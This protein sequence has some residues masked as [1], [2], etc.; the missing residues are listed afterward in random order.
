MAMGDQR[1]SVTKLRVYL[2][3]DSAIMSPVLR[4]LIEATG[5]RIVGNSGAARTSIEDIKVLRP[6][7]V[8]VD[9]MLPGMDGFETAQI[10]RGRERSRHTPII[11]LTAINTSDTHVSRG[12]ELGA[13]DYLPKPF[14]PDQVRHAARRVV[15]ANVLRR[16]MS[17]LQD[18]LDESEGE[19]T[20]ETQSSSYA[21]FLQTVARAAASDSVILL[22]GE[23]GTGKTV[24]A[25]WIRAARHA[26][27]TSRYPSTTASAE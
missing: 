6:D 21:A 16:Q 19:A 18:R 5:A 23:S 26:R 11:F 25:R 15:A 12:Y 22:R 13:V 8:I 3:E 9:R 20:L 2:V 4:T 27:Y 10:I 17:E 24:L 7:V 1:E 14:T